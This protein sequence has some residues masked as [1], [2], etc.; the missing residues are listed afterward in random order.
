[1]R[2][3]ANQPVGILRSSRSRSI[4]TR[5]RATPPDFSPAFFYR[6]APFL[7]PATGSGGGF[8]CYPELM[9]A[10]FAETNPATWGAYFNDLIEEDDLREREAA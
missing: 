1:M 3:R 7:S 10:D 9:D 4:L 6:N 2:A 5:I 8:R